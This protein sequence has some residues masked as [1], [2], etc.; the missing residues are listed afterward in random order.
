MS[1]ITTFIGWFPVLVCTVSYGILSNLCVEEYQCGSAVAGTFWKGLDSLHLYGCS[2]AP[3]HHSPSMCTIQRPWKIRCHALA[4]LGSSESS[5]LFT[6]QDNL[7]GDRKRSSHIMWPKDG[8]GPAGALHWVRTKRAVGLL[9][10]RGCKRSNKEWKIEGEDTLPRLITS[11]PCWHW[12]L[13][14]NKLS[15]H[16]LWSRHTCKHSHIHTLNTLSLLYY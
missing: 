2:Q 14:Q 7:I 3:R 13:T 9:G 1:C 4:A 6:L 15:M 12:Q 10:F 5:T 11:S 8:V 16:V